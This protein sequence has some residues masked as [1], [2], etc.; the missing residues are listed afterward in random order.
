MSY[1][2]LGV[3][4]NNLLSGDVVIS[5]GSDDFGD[6]WVGGG[7]STR[8]G[9][10]SAKHFHVVRFDHLSTPSGIRITPAALRVESIIS[11]QRFTIVH[12]QISEPV[13]IPLYVGWGTSRHGRLGQAPFSDSKPP[14]FTSLPRIIEVDDVL[15][16]AFI[17]VYASTHR[18]GKY[19]LWDPI[20]KA[21]S[22]YS[23]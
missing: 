10:Q 14:T 17:T 1:G 8:T 18:R 5:L 21:N 19:L 16:S 9:K 22:S 20:G 23:H 7:S 2:K 3:G 13:R 4:L 12:I 11:G 15:S 6:L